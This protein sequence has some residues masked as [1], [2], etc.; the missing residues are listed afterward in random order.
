MPAE[1]RLL[2]RARCEE[3]FGAAVEA[4]R[5]RGV[6][7]V[8]VTLWAAREA[9]T[10]FAN[11]VIH[12]N[13]EESS[14]WLSVR[15]VIGARTAR[16][17]TNRLDPDS[18]RSVVEEAIAI[19]KASEADPELP[20]LAEPAPVA[21][22]ERY[23]AETAACGPA[24]R[25]EKVAEAIDAVR[26][27][28]QRAAGIYSTGEFVHAV[29]NSRGVFAYHIET[30]SVCSVTAMAGDSSGWA[31]ESAPDHRRLDPAGLA[32]RA[33]EK[34]SGS[35]RPI[36]LGPGRYTVILEPAA[37][38]DLVGQIF[39]DFSGTALEEQRSFLN[40]R[41]GK[42]LFG[43]NITIRDDVFHPLQGGAPF[44]GEGVPRRALLLVRRGVPVEVAYGRRAAAK[45]GVEP[46]GHGF[47]VPNE[48]GEAP[49]NIVIEGGETRLEE[50]IGSTERGILVTRLWY[51]REVDPYEKIMT[52]MTR[53]G[54]FLIEGGRLVRGIR[55]LRFNQSVPAMLR[56]VEAMS[57][58]VRAAG[59]EAFDMVVPAMKVQDF[60]FTEV[61]RF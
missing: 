59:E 1:S 23:Y 4:A 30:R 43:E 26:S 36:E 22:A 34:A 20:P 55:N 53:D 24:E 35:G 32:R 19:T 27:A 31:K 57:R 29:V 6:A 61:T 5:V 18:V 52:G 8:E 16:A 2:S 41:M 12:Q 39:D 47:P 45:A 48:A 42:P 54:T 56:K 11:N 38:V 51:I 50:L 3:I 13:M 40:D 58:A 33:A 7:D 60:R 21:A 25:A 49:A 14:G 17:T 28:G 15:P 46:T 10:R 9:L 37:V 44:D